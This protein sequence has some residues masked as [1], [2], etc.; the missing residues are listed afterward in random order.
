LPPFVI[1]ILAVVEARKF[2]RTSKMPEL[3]I[4]VNNK[5]YL[6]SPKYY[7]LHAENLVQFSSKSLNTG[8][9]LNNIAIV[10]YQE[11]IPKS[12]QINIL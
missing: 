1:A 11:F 6:N 7:L 4:T 2:C 12:R 10:Q 9:W 3:K 5:P 8:V